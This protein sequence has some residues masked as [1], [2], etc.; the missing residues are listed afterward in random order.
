MNTQSFR[1]NSGLDQFRTICA[2]RF[3]E[4]LPEGEKNGKLVDWLP[5]IVEDP[6]EWERFRASLHI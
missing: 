3:A 2:L 1:A 6:K 4:V 5:R